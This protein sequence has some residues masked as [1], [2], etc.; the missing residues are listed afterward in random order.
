MRASNEWATDELKDLCSAIRSN[1]ETATPDHVSLIEELANELREVREANPGWSSPPTEEVTRRLRVAAWLMLEVSLKLVQRVK[2]AWEALP[3]HDPDAKRSAESTALVDRVAN[4]A[5]YLAWRDFCPRALGAIRAQALAASKRDTVAGFRRAWLLHKEADKRFD[6]YKAAAGVDPELLLHFDETLVMLRLAQTGTACRTAELTINRTV[7]GSSR[8]TTEKA[9]LNKLF[10]DLD[11]GANYGDQTIEAVRGVHRKHGLVTMVDEERFTLDTS[12]R[13]PGIMTARAYLLMYPITALLE[14]QN[15]GTWKD[16]PSW[17]H[18]RERLIEKFLEAYRAIEYQGSQ[19]PL[20]VDFERSII[21]LRL[22]L[23]IVNP[24]FELP[25]AHTFAPCLKR[26]VL[27]EEA[28]EELSQWLAQ[29]DAKGKRRGDA[30]VIGSATMPSYLTAIHLVRGGTED[31][32][33]QYAEWR[34]RWFNLDRH[35]AET[36]RKDIVTAALAGVQVI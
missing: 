13:N 36:T 20:T 21:Q 18:V 26:T 32:W 3:T 16:L 8:S 29:L 35:V 28:I 25:S 9:R 22:N 17:K 30:N 12:Y 11:Q 14:Q 34:H 23:A 33:K 5:R 24:G 15:R 1:A 4:S 31:A 27:D 10:R 6:E 19:T 2:P 7:A